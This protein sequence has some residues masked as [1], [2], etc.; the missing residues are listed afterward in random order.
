MQQKRTV[1][2]G[3]LYA[4]RAEATWGI[5]C[6]LWVNL[7]IGSQ[8]VQL[9]SYS[10]I[11]DSQQGREAVNTEAEEATALEAVTRQ[12]LVKRQQTEKT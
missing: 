5:N 2:T 12:W 7:A 4:V 8:V 3:V 10:E 11:G 9:G 1:G 6:A